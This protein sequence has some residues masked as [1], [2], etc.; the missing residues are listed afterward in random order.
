[1][2]REVSQWM[3]GHVYDEESNP[4]MP[5][6]ATRG[7]DSVVWNRLYS[8]DPSALD[9]YQ[10]N[11]ARAQSIELPPSH[12]SLHPALVNRVAMA[13][14]FQVQAVLEDT[15]RSLG[16]K[17]MVVGHTPQPTGANRYHPLLLLK[18]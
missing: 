15:L 6:V 2:N 17:G 16:A 18:R 3:R 11:Q 1:M 10:M 7:Y 14:C 12:T 5:F 8:R 13:R 4:D 9:G